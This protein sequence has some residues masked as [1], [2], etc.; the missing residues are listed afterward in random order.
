MTILSCCNVMRDRKIDL[1][2]ATTGSC[3]SINAF[4]DAMERKVRLCGLPG[5][6]ATKLKTYTF[7]SKK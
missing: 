7:S 6:M 3:Q 5:N 1:I 2:V 4:L